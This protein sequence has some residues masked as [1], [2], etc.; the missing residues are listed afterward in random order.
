MVLFE[1]QKLYLR[2]NLSVKLL[3]FLLKR[4][5]FGNNS[6]KKKPKIAAHFFHPLSFLKYAFSISFDNSFLVEINKN[7]FKISKKL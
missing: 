3:N 5:F 4:S 1:S 2:L 6:T 7:T